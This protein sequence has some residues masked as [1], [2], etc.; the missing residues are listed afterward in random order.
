MLVSV[1]AGV[2]WRCVCIC[3]SIQ[4]IY[5]RKIVQTIPKS[6]YNRVKKCYNA[7]KSSKIMNNSNAFSK[8]K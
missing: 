3:V 8:L 7:M 1:I 4:Q 2:I 5:L 6:G